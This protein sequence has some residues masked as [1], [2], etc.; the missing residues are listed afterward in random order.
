MNDED[1]EYRALIQR[2]VLNIMGQYCYLRLLRSGGSAIDL[3][4]LARRS[5]G[6]T[7]RMSDEQS[8]RLTVDLIIA[9]VDADLRYMVGSGSVCAIYVRREV[10]AEKWQDV[11][12]KAK[13]SVSRAKDIVAAVTA[14][15]FAHIIARNITQS[16]AAPLAA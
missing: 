1:R 6:A 11:A 3:A 7:D 13:C 14:K 15:L 8:W 2:E 16:Y 9:A 5:G 4:K 12:A 10:F